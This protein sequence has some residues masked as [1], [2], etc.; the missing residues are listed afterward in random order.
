MHFY[1]SRLT[2]KLDVFSFPLAK[3]AVIRFLL[4]L[5]T[6]LFHERSMNAML[7][8]FSSLRRSAFRKAYNANFQTEQTC[9]PSSTSSRANATGLAE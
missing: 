2:I 4:S 6:R 3:H 7:R 1:T 9:L 8:K 5:M